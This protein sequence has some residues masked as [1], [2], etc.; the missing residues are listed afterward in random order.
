ME[1]EILGLESF[2]YGGPEKLGNIMLAREVIKAKGTWES[3]MET[4]S[5]PTQGEQLIGE[6]S[7]TQGMREVGRTPRLKVQ[8]GEMWPG[9]A[10]A[11]T[12]DT[13]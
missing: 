4:T 6:D 1:K 13:E 10:L 9:A 5:L 11:K 8:V 2:K 7:R 3:C 12:K